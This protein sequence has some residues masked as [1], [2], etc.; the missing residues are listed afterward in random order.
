MKVLASIAYRYL[1]KYTGTA[2]NIVKSEL[3]KLK[4]TTWSYM[5]YPKKINPQT[6]LIIIFP[7]FDFLTVLKKNFFLSSISSLWIS[8]SFNPCSAALFF[9]SSSYFYFF[10][11]FFSDSSPSSLL[12]T[13]DLVSSSIGTIISFYSSSDLFFLFLSSLPFFLS[14]WL[15]CFEI[16]LFDYLS[17][18]LALFWSL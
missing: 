17:F 7:Q 10:L 8:N 5:K 14:L 4:W 2:S 11:C 3:L 18:R 13:A 9:S 6:R 12:V 1:S 15:G 16:V